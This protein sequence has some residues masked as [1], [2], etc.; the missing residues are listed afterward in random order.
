MYQDVNDK[1][2][3]NLNINYN[4]ISK[5]FLRDILVKKKNYLSNPE[6]NK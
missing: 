6:I 1:L 5:T 3:A 2:K 4:S